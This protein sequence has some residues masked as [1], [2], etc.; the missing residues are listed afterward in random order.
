MF[1]CGI[2]HHLFHTDDRGPTGTVSVGLELGRLDGWGKWTSTCPPP[3]RPCVGTH[4][5]RSPP[6]C[7][8]LTSVYIDFDY[9]VEDL[10]G[11]SIEC[12]PKYFLSRTILTS[13]RRGRAVI[14][15]VTGARMRNLRSGTRLPAVGEG[16][17]GYCPA[18]EENILSMVNKEP[19]IYERTMEHFVTDCWKG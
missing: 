14:T 10:D 6:S 9:P 17:E 19:P 15:H 4:N 3:P 1:P 7:S 13:V 16:D 2:L 8:S 18:M 5:H 12:G 11:P